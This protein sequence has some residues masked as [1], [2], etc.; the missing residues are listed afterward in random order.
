MM[1]DRFLIGRW[2]DQAQEWREVATV[3]ASNPSRAQA[4]FLAGEWDGDAGRLAVKYADVDTHGGIW[5]DK[6]A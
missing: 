6:S 4:K 3:V 1:Q 2:H 5:R